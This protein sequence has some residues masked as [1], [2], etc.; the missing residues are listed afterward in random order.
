MYIFYTL[1]AETCVRIE[2]VIDGLEV[3]DFVVLN[4]PNNVAEPFYIAQVQNLCTKFV[5]MIP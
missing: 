1:P 2:K 5:F 4:A 3:K